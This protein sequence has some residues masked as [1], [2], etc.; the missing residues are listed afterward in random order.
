MNTLRVIYQH[1]ELIRGLVG[2]NLRASHR[3]KALGQLWALLNPLVHLGVL[4][5]IFNAFR[6][7]KQAFVVY[8]MIGIVFWN[9]MMSIL[10]GMGDCLRR[11]KTIYLRTPLPVIV[12][13][14]VLLLERFSDFFWGFLACALIVV[15]MIWFGAYPYQV[16]PLIW[17]LPFVLLGFGAYIFGLGLIIA[18]LGAFYVDVQDFMAQ[19]TRLGFFLTPVLWEPAQMWKGSF[20]AWYFYLYPGAGWM[21]LARQVITAPAEAV[22]YQVQLPY[23]TLYLVCSS[24]A[25]L[26]AGLW[27]FQARARVYTKYV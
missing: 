2:F 18:R 8:L 21:M 16:N 7:N 1:R 17:T 4:F 10:T 14:V 15:G 12:F 11:S 13:P 5:L 19:T 25:W 26:V 20:Y 27:F 23:Y 3:H 9:V 24:I 22:H 6:H